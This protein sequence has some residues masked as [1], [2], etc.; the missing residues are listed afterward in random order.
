MEKKIKIREY[1]SN[2][3]EKIID[4]L[5]LNTPKYFAEEEAKDLIYYL[6]NEIESYYVIELDNE[7]VGSG[8]IN[9]KENGTIGFISWDLLNP[10]FQRKGLGTLIL[11]YR[12]EK[13]NENKEIK[14]IIVRTTQ[15]V[16]KFYEKSGFKIIKEVKD[17]WAKG[18]DL[19]TMEFKKK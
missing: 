9:L 12:I 17:Y 7:I 13:L 8:G 5:K 4:L 3:K 16:Y 2:D 14:Q 11:N 19:Y 1:T 10:E 15:L 6:D 18:F